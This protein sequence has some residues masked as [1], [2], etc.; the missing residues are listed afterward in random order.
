MINLLPSELKASYRYAHRNVS[1]FR[2]VIALTAGLAG[3]FALS[4][5][6]LIY[7]QQTTRTYASQ[8]ASAQASLQQQNLADT[9]AQVKGISGNLQL[10]VQVLSKEVLFS[11][12]LTQLAAVMPGNAI[13]TD[14]NITQAQSAVNITADT[15][16]YNAA[17]QLQVNLADPN[18]KIFSRAD[19][20]SITCASASSAQTG[21]SSRYPCT[22]NIRAL[23]ATNNPF[24]FINNK[25]A[26]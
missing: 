7:M 9:Q 19:I 5:A 15:T 26:Q 8:A 23:F 13:L 20:V 10:A 25:A 17:T 14:L 6:G 16:D 4:T 2:W 21:L 1:L 24:L 18:N 22:V 12:L 3:L 11:K